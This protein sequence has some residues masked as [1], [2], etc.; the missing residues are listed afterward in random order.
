MNKSGALAMTVYGRASKASMQLSWVGGLGNGASV[1]PG[2][3]TGYS[4]ATIKNPVP[5]HEKSHKEIR[6]RQY[7]F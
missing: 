4:L 3:D 5:F 7:I 6:A 1:R 2:D